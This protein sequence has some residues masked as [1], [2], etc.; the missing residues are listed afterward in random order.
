MNDKPLDEKN[1]DYGWLEGACGELEVRWHK[2]TGIIETKTEF[3]GW[4]HNP[5]FAHMNHPPKKD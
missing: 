3:G 4:A 5:I 2:K 1:Y